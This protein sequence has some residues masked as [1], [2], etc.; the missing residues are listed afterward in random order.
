VG[1]CKNES[2]NDGLTGKYLYKYLR[3]K[4][5]VI[6]VG[7]KLKTKKEWHIREGKNTRIVGSFEKTEI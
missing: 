3:D 6:L 2:L 4:N 1:F 7:R 5:N